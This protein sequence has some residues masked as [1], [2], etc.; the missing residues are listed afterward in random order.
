MTQVRTGSRL[1]DAESYYLDASLLL[2]LLSGLFLGLPPGLLLFMLDL[3][4]H[5]DG[6]NVNIASGKL[7]DHES[8]NTFIRLR[9]ARASKPLTIFVIMVALPL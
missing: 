1:A 8:M 6:V 9:R 5:S 3:I 4:R 7:T 2:S